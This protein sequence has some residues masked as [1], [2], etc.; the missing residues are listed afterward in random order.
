MPHWIPSWPEAWGA[1]VV[2]ALLA[3]ILL[4]RLQRPSVVPALLRE[5]AVV[6]G[7][8]GLWQLVGSQAVRTVNDA[9]ARGEAI[10]HVERALHLP[11]EASIQH[12]TAPHPWL[13]E[14]FNG[15]YVYA[16]FS[17][18]GL[19]LLWVFLRHRAAYP[20]ARNAV[21]FTTF[22]CLVVSLVAVAPPRLLDAR[23]GITDSAAAFGQSV[24]GPLGTGIADQCSAMPS[25]H[26]AWATLVGVFVYR[27]GAGRARWLG[28]LH[29]TLTLTVVVATGNHYWLDAIVAGLIVAASVVATSR[30]SAG[31]IDRDGESRADLPHA[32][33]GQ[34]AESLH[35]HSH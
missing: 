33:V 1:A 2:L 31:A 12:L 8:F 11:S 17:S 22:A 6:A 30:V 16:H 21:A 7:L 19:M 14:F 29:T 28:P 13:V 15:Y 20:R 27:L 3:R 9:R 10:W 18:L 32:A 5:V 34:A 23:Y 24:Y 4:V 25:V 35:E 26:V